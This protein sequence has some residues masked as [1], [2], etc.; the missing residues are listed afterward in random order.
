[1]QALSFTAR[2]FYR[3]PAVFRYKQAALAARTASTPLAVRERRDKKFGKL[4][5]GTSDDI[6]GLTPSEYATFERRL[7]T[8][9]I[10]PGVTPLKWIHRVN[11]R[12]ARIRGFKI[13]RTGENQSD[14]IPVGRPVY[15]PNI[16]FRLVRNHT[17]EG[18]PYNPYEA[19][20]RVPRSVTKVDIR[21]YLLAMYGVQTTYIRT[22]NYIGDLRRAQVGKERKHPAYK[23]AVV[24]L[25]EPFYYP[26][27]LEDM[28]QESR[29]EREDWIES[30]FMIKEAK[31]REY[32][33]RMAMLQRRDDVDFRKSVEGRTQI[34]KHI[35]RRKEA[36]Q[37]LVMKQA[38][39]WSKQRAKGVTITIG[40]PDKGVTTV[41][42]KS[43]TTPSPSNYGA[44]HPLDGWEGV[45]F[46]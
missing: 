13:M 8:G 26:K 14:I 1:M 2:R 28:S 36:R 9:K 35:A 43:T 17:P 42:E 24:G 38:E 18:Q 7:A 46:D 27:R 34:L 39:E 25:A 44:D 19:T 31:A 21:S 3:R 12:R 32:L 33:V 16:V 5:P 15:L 41:D 20:F 30:I 23:R 37:A 40:K 11:A 4:E 10:P 6:H 29:K 22:D 45:N